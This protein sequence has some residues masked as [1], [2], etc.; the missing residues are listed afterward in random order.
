LGTESL[1]DVLLE[2]TRSGPPSGW[3]HRLLGHRAR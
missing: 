2:T 3:G 1:L